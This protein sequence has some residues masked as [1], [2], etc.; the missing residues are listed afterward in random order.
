MANHFL[1]AT[2]FSLSADSHGHAAANLLYP[3][4]E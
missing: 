4:L 2:M 1:T 3:A